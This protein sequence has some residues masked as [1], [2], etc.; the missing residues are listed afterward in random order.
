MKTFSGSLL[1]HQQENVEKLLALRNSAD[2]SECGTGKTVSILYKLVQLINKGA[3]TRTLIVC[4]LSVITTWA[5]EIQKYTDLSYARLVGSLSQKLQALSYDC[6]IY[7]ISYDS[8][9]GRDNT[10]GKLLSALLSRSF[11]LLVCDEVSMLKHGGTNRTKA[12][13]FLADRIP[14][15]HF[16]SG[17]PVTNSPMDVLSI[18]RALDSGRTFGKNLWKAKHFWF[19][20]I[21]GRFPEWV[22]RDD[23]KELF[24]DRFYSIA[25]RSR[26]AEC[27]DLPEQIMEPRYCYLSDEQ[28]SVYRPIAKLL[29][30]QLE[31]EG[32]SISVPNA[33]TRLGKLQQ[34]TAGFVYT[35]DGAHKFKDNPK[36]ALLDEQLDKFPN[37]HIL[38][39]TR[40]K[41]EQEILHEHLQSSG[42]ELRFMDGESSLPEREDIVRSFGV[43]TRPQILVANLNVGKYSFTFTGSHTIFYFSL[44]FGLEEWIQSQN[45]IHRI[46]QHHQCIYS[47][48][49]MDDTVDIYVYD[50]IMQRLDI[51]KDLVDGS[52]LR[53]ILRKEAEDEHV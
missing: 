52:R 15:K 12:L 32:K 25:V 5:I 28:R 47:P 40:W 1:K 27:L 26:K 11:D 24:R 46:G 31:V 18:Y 3:V 49:M 4:P 16:M 2:W 30:K 33:L 10:Q 48:L 17:T 13:T 6:D 35:E 19:K 41:T 23:K 14:Y 29:L 39:Y 20:D 45:R 7:L 34:I 9:H 21:G 43:G 53:E 42:R 36:L 44:S 50:T 37:E 8:L 38:I 22:M 51:A